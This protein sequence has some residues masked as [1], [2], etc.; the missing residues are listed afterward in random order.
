[1]FVPITTAAIVNLASFVCGLI[2]IWKSGGA[3]EHLFAQMLV[4]GFGVVNCWPIYEAMALRNDEGK[5]P[6]KL[7]FFSISLAL[8]LS[9]FASFFH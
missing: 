3:W 1:M 2:R 7:T 6:P 9:Y 8:L 5:L 4:A